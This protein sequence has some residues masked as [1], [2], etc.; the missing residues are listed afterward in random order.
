MKSIHQSRWQDRGIHGCFSNESFSGF[1]RDL[2]S[3]TCES[4]QSFITILRWR[5]TPAAGGIFFI[6]D[7]TM[8]IYLASMASNSSVQN[9]G[10]KLNGLLCDYALERGCRQVDF[11]RGDED[12]KARMG[13][14]PF[15]QE[16]WMVSSPRFLGRVHR[17]LYRTAREIKH[18]ITVP[19]VPPSVS[20]PVPTS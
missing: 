17:T 12:Y 18:F 19:T 5:G 7:T 2:I 20:E 3:Q 16:R 8:Y 4:G 11:M 1:V 15:A 14:V 10:W 13:A 9:P 6:D